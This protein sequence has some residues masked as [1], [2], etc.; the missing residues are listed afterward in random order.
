MEKGFIALA[1]GILDHPIVGAHKPYTKKDAWEWLLFEAAYLLRRYDAG[2]T[3][4]NLQRGQLAH[5]TRFMARAWGW[6]ETNV[7]R[8]LDL[9][10]TG[11][12]TGAMIGAETGAGVTVITICNYERYQT[13]GAGS[14]AANGAASGAAGGAKV[15]QD[16]RRKEQGN[17]VTSSNSP[18]GFDEWY[19]I[20]PRKKAKQDAL[21]AYSKLIGSGAISHVPLL[22]KTK[23][24]A[25]HWHA[26]P[27]D[28][29]QFCPYPASWLNSGEYADE[30]TQ[31]AKANNGAASIKIERPTKDPE[32]FSADDWQQRLGMGQW[33]SLWGPKPGEPGCLVPAALLVRPIGAEPMDDRRDAMSRPASIPHGGASQ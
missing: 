25:S 27:A 9:L 31:A 26:R 29:L 24:F 14:G 23:A 22:E 13:P 33:S 21:K 30:I 1:R 10:K 8:F 15:A 28:Q 12:G 3:V 7:R 17:K 20:Y 18:P 2:G 32:T 19:S 6:P 4:C 16:R 11:A 5:S